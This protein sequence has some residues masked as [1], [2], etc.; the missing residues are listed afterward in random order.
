MPLIVLPPGADSLLRLAIALAFVTAIGGPLLLMAWVRTPLERGDREPIEQPFQFDHRHHVRDD[1]IDCLHCH[2]DATRSP[3]AGVPDTELC[4]GCHGQIWPES[5]EL[6][7]LRASWRERTPIAWR[8]VADLPDFV[9]F[10]HSAHVRRGVGCETCHGRV[11]LMPIVHRAKS[12]RMTFCT[13]CHADPDPHL[14]P[15]SE[16]TATGVALDRE[17]GRRIRA[18]RGISPPTDCTGCHR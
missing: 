15:Q 11:D 9:F 4:M 3:Y 14:R 6:A 2:F 12:F 1:G 8:R 17:R 18:E 5:P 16:I 13:D 10:D 7:E